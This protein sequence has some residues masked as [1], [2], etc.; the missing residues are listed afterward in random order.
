MEANKLVKSKTVYGVDFAV[1]SD[2][3]GAIFFDKL[4]WA[5]LLS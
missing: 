1:A 5:T 2:F 4:D 3:Y